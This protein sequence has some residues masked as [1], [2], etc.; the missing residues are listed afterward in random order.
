MPYLPFD[1]LVTTTR[2]GWILTGTTDQGLGHLRT[3]AP[4]LLDGTSVLFVESEW[5]AEAFEA[6]DALGLATF[7]LG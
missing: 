5:A 3:L 1:I 7:T 6:I 2:R 4:E